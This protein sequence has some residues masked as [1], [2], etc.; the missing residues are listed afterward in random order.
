MTFFEKITDP[1]EL[2]QWK[3]N[4]EANYLYTSGQAGEDFFQGLMEGKFLANECPECGKVYA[5]PRLYCE[6]CFVEIG[7]DYQELEGTGTVD[8]YTVARINTYEKELEEPEVWAIVRFDGADSGLTHKIDADPSE[9]EPGMEVKPV[10]KP[11]S[12]R[13]GTIKDI[14]CFEPV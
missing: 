3:G 13:E 10:L 2:L 12:E 7:D 11:E 5:P 8:C 6:D 14:E 9:I 4:M 1:R